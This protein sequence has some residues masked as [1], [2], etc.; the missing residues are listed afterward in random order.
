MT[1]KQPAR[2]IKNRMGDTLRKTILEH[3]GIVTEQDRKPKIT[4]R[5]CPKCETVNA[6]ENDY[7]SKKDCGYPL[8]PKGYERR[9]E[10]EKKEMEEL[11]EKKI[12]DIF[13][14]VDLGKL[15]GQVP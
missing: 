12:Q 4:S 10:S 13:G 7:C 5:P 14:R 11:V 8:T 1:S 6:L 3:N 9:K 15:R 2:Y